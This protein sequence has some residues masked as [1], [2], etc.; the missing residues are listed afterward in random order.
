MKKLIAAGA[1]AIVSCFAAVAQNHEAEAE[2]RGFMIQYD[3]AVAERN[4]A[5]L[6]AVL[7]EDYVYTGANGRA[8]D[9]ARVLAFFRRV[10]EKPSS[11]MVSLVHDNI[12]ARVVG[13]M[14]VVTNDYMSRTVPIDAPDSEPQTTRGRHMVAF[15]KRRGR[16]M[17]IAE[18]DTEQPNDD[19]KL[20]E[21]QVL[22]ARR[23]Y[24][25]LVK[26]LK[27]GLSYTELEKKGDIAAL[28]RVLADGYIYTS[29]NGKISTKTQEL[30]GYRTNQV[31]LESAVLL[32][33]KV[34][35]VDNYTAVETGMIRYVGTNAGKPFDVTKRYTTTWIGW[36]G[37]WQIVSHHTSAV[38]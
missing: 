15:E 11:R 20:M 6:K 28:R 25:D 35:L 33:Q 24:N 13:D 2:V 17:V 8:A 37:Q 18:Q 36:S 31:K 9:R 21:Q 4:I 38:E 22:K 16:W 10:K 14:A 1:L 29:H 5:F 30:E 27:S 23:E 19:D 7:A 12:K 26:R 34:R 3:K 32:D